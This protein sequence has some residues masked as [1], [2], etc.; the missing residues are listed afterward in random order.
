[1]FVKVE[2]PGKYNIC[3]VADKVPEQA[4]LTRAFF[5][6]L[7]HNHTFSKPDNRMDYANSF[8]GL[9]NET[10]SDVKLQ[11]DRIEQVKTIFVKTGWTFLVIGVMGVV[12]F[13]SV[14]WCSGRW[15]GMEVA[16]RM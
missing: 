13:T 2:W 5:F 16:K 9:S 3:F 6:E 11:S 14:V 10:W 7:D 1:M 15:V 8:W 4:N 12:V